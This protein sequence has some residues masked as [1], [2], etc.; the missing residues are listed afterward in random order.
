[1]E[2]T[3]KGCTIDTGHFF[4]TSL[5]QGLVFNAFPKVKN[6]KVGS[7]LR[8]PEDFEGLRILKNLI[9]L[10]GEIIV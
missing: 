6:P 8:A 7:F 5:A 2:I 10:K 3:V 9:F 1:V 4:H